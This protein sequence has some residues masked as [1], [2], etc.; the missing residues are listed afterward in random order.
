VCDSINVMT[1][2]RSV[3]KWMRAKGHWVV[4]SRDLGA[5]VDNGDLL[6]SIVTNGRSG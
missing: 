1:I 5:G 2:D 3:M 4:M 6:S